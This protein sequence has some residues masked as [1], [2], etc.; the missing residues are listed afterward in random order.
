MSILSILGIGVVVLLAI[1]LAWVLLL[2][3][4]PVLVG[5]LGWLV[6]VGLP[7]L[8]MLAG[9]VSCL[10]SNKS[11]S[12]KALWLLVIFLAPFIGPLLWFLWGK[13]HT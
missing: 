4:V 8:L 3:I 7:A 9:I 10:W 6:I 1:V 2:V 11:T 5:V 12:L 13:H